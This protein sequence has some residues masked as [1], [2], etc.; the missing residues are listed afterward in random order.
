MNWSSLP[1]VVLDLDNSVRR[2]ADNEVRR[3]LQDWQ[4]S[5]RYGCSRSELSRLEKHLTLPPEH[6]CLFLGSGDYHHLSLL[7]LQR[8][9]AA[10]EAFEVVV[11]DNHPDNMRYPFGVHCGSWIYWACRLPAVSHVHVIGI[12]SADITWSHAWE[13]YLTPFLA[14]RL[15]YWSIGPDAPWLGWL[16]RRQ[17][18]RR[19]ETA[20]EL[21]TAFAGRL[22]TAR[23]IYLSIDKDVF[24]QDLIRTNWD[25]G[26]FEKRHLAQ[27]IQACAGK[28]IGVDI[29][30]EI[31]RYEYQ[32]IFK[33]L[34]T[35]LDTQVKL[36]ISRLQA[37]QSQQHLFNLEVLALLKQAGH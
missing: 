34:L 31:S 7:P 35:R 18:C 33:K 24:Q 4:E 9:A 11:C 21:L 12:T 13:N 28:L 5:V 29:T 8:L 15:T 19:S 30:G 36:D 14:G 3:P 6:G 27:L 20:D 22:A 26:V 10:G 25:Q 17:H 1:P 23:R 37:W 16:G 2:V 32:G